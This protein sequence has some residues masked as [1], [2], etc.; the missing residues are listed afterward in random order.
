M[1]RITT[2]L[3]AL[4]LAVACAL[5]LPAAAST[6]A[7]ET[8]CSSSADMEAGTKPG[9][10]L[11]EYSV[12]ANTEGTSLGVRKIEIYKMN[13]DYVATYLGSVNN[14]LI[15]KNDSFHMGTYIYNN[16]VSGQYY[17]AEV[18]VFVTTA[19][20]TDDYTQTTPT[21]KAP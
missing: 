16:A 17:Y 19:T 14:G 18:T 3:L 20:A 12:S 9:Q 13:G 6:Y 1:K 5:S 8:I 15:I 2:F 11:I 21:I 10:L 4:A 7:S